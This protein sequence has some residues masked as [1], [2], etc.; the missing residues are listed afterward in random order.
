MKLKFFVLITFVI[1]GALSTAGQKAEPKRIK[2]AKGT[3][4]KTVTGVLSNNQQQEYV[5]GAQQGQTLTVLITSRPRGKYH[6][7]NILGDGI[8]FA[9]DYDVNYSYQVRLPESGDYLIYVTKRPT[10][11]NK[12]ARFYL[13]VKVVN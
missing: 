5:I 3:N 9:T 4:S 8:D 11:R 2:F 6:S 13:K 10:K 7:F 1:F 12:T